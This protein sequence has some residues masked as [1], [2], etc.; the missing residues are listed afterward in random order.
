MS[1]PALIG[2][3]GT[4]FLLS[5]ALMIVF[6]YSKIQSGEPISGIEVGIAIL[7]VVGMGVLIIV[8]IIA[9]QTLCSVGIIG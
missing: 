3:I 4:V 5:L 2:L 7:M 6:G 1:Y 9:I 8:G